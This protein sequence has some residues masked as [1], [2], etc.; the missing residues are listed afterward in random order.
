MEMF[1]DARAFVSPATEGPDAVVEAVERALLRIAVGERLDRAGLMATEHLATGGKRVRGRLALA[2]CASFGLTP[3]ESVSWAAAVELLHN[4]TLVHDDIQDGDELRRGRPTVWARHGV[5]QAINTGDL[6]LML[7][8]LAVAEIPAPEKLRF[9][10]SQAVANRAARTV[11]GQV[12]E[13]ELLASRKLDRGSYLRASLGKTGHLLALP[14][15]GAALL[16]GRSV[17]T[18]RSLAAPFEDLGLLFQLQ[19][20]LVDLYGDKGRDAPGADLRE[21]KVSALVVAHMELVPEDREWLLRI[22]DAPRE[23]TSAADVLE[24]TRRFRSGGA[25]AAVLAWIDALAARVH[26]APELTDHPALRALARN[27]VQLVLG[28]I[29]HLRSAR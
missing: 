29:F 27:M 10:L 17:P 7:P 13:L 26:D 2:A 14:V 11:R 1:Q 4:A 3:E 23:G 18:A 6:L 25:L 19:D 8:W 9:R 5:A 28:P 24:V 22:L 21:G 15:E 16:G 12:D 20:D